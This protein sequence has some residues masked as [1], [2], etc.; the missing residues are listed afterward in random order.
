MMLT[1]QVVALGLVGL[2]LGS[3]PAPAQ[4]GRIAH[5][6]H[7]G[8]AATLARA[9]AGADNFGLWQEYKYTK[10]TRLN[11]SLVLVEGQKR[12]PGEEWEPLKQHYGGSWNRHHAS[13]QEIIMRIR[14]QFPGAVLVGFG[15]KGAKKT[16]RQRQS[17]VIFPL[18]PPS[19]P[20]QPSGVWLALIVIVGLGMA[21]LLLHEKALP[22]LRR[23]A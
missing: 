2:L 14:E 3:V 11:D 17:G 5:F 12:W 10:V 23:V 18:L 1:K 7:G 19:V 8:S 15:T 9:E 6:S 21:G 20:P 22:T 4:T 16:P 13:L